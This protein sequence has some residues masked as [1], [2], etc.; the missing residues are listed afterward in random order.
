MKDRLRLLAIKL[1]NLA[2]RRGRE[3][4]LA[5]WKRKAESMPGN[6]KALFAVDTKTDLLSRV[7][8][9]FI[10]AGWLI[11]AP[12]NLLLEI[13]VEVDGQLRAKAV[14]GLRRQDVAD[15]LPDQAG[16]LWSGFAAEVFIDDLADRKVSVE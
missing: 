2:H 7:R 15:A 9:P 11:P 8:S 10:V 6:Q 12:E 1:V 14:T 3:W 5:R 13:L 16:A 4:R